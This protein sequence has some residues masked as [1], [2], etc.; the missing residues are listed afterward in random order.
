MRTA[1]KCD[2]KVL[3]GLLSGVKGMPSQQE[4]LQSITSGY[5]AAMK[6]NVSQ[7]WIVVRLKEGGKMGTLPKGQRGRVKGQK[8]ARKAKAT[9]KVERA[10][11][12]QRVREDVRQESEQETQG[13]VKY[14]AQRGVENNALENILGADAL[15]TDTVKM[16]NGKDFDMDEY[17]RL[18]KKLT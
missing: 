12:Q 5:N 10:P 17:K 7:S 16:P 6:Q 13:T 4:A 18:T 8:V 2:K 9:K 3:Y 1:I 14:I 11:K 15:A